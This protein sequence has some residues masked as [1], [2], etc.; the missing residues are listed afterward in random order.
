MRKLWRHRWRIAGY[1]ITTAMITSGMDY[2][3]GWEGHVYWLDAAWWGTTGFAFGL[4]PGDDE[5]IG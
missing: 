4:V 5:K 2:F 3:L 1:F